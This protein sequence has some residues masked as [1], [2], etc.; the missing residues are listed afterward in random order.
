MQTGPATEP[1]A[2]APTAVVSNT[3]DKTEQSAITPDA[4]LARLKEGNVRFV[5]GES[6]R[7]DYPAQVKATAAGQYPFAAVLSCMDSRSSPEIVFDQGIGDLFVVRIAG[8]YAQA[9]IIGSIEYATKVA[10]A[11]LV[12]VMGHTE[13]GAI[14]GACDNVT[15]GNLTTVIQALQPAVDD[16]KDI[17]D[18]RTSKN[19]KFVRLVTEANV[20]RTVAKLRADSPIL[21]DLEQSGQIKIVGA[22]NDISTGQ[23]TFYDWDG[24]HN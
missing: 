12:V 8:N 19:K 9:D 22:I 13:C 17:Q 5:G 14:K 2:T 11:K 7:R 6:L 20:R 24:P 21:H 4:A 10:G 18:D 1:L 3:I 16:V 15:L 23:V